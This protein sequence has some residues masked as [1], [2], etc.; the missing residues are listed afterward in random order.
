M[1]ALSVVKT[2]TLW[3]WDEQNPHLNPLTL[4]PGLTCLCLV[5]PSVLQKLPPW[6]LVQAV[7]CSV[8][9]GFTLDVEGRG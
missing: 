6:A 8:P 5:I 1:Q 4:I 7:S 3:H 2:T 9:S